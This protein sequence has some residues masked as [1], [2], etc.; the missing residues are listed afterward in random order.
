MVQGGSKAFQEEILH[1]AIVDCY[2]QLSKATRH[3]Q[4]FSEDDLQKEE[5]RLKR[6]SNIVLVDYIKGMTELLYS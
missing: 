1:S 5:A 2:M 6:L 3:D 4:E